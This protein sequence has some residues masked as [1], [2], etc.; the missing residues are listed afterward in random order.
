MDSKIDIQKNS[1]TLWSICT[2]ISSIFVLFI[3]MFQEQAHK[4][5]LM[6]YNYSN[7]YLS[8]YRLQYGL[9]S[10]GM[11]LGG[12]SVLAFI[13]FFAIRN[14]NEEVASRKEKTLRFGKQLLIVLMVVLAL[15]AGAK[16]INNYLQQDNMDFYTRKCS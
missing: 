7:Y 6:M 5:Y 4:P 14:K 10:F 9:L 2:L 11:I 15:F 8:L 3:N 16:M 13:Y 12:A 1:L